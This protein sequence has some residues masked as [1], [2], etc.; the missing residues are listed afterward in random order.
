MNGGWCLFGCNKESTYNMPQ[1]ARDKWT[2]NSY[3]PDI[4]SDRS[5]NRRYQDIDYILIILND[6]SST[7]WKPAIYRF[8]NFIMCCTENIAGEYDDLLKEKIIKI[9]QKIHSTSRFR[10]EAKRLIGGIYK[11]HTNLRIERE[12]YLSFKK[13]IDSGNIKYLVDKYGFSKVL[14]FILTTSI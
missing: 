11:N 6:D 13:I 3:C 14:L 1:Y 12:E 9:I 2:K 5:C 7:R 4:L 8:V 10:D